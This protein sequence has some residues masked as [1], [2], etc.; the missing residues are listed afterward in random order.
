M[1]E[2][3][4]GDKVKIRKDLVLWKIYG[5]LMLD[6]KMLKFL[7]SEV[8]VFD[9]SDNMYLVRENTHVWTKEMLDLKQK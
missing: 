9:G 7:G 8:T 2:I 5:G 1:K 6:P 3:K 4:N